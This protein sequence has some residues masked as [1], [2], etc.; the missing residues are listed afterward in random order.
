MTPDGVIGLDNNIPWRLPSDMKRFRGI[1]KEAGVVPMGRKTWDSLPAQFK[2]LKERYNV[3]LTR[4]CSLRTSDSVEFV[5]TLEDVYAAIAA[6]GGKGCIIGGEQIYRLFLPVVRVMH[7]TTVYASIAG[8][9]H[10]PQIDLKDWRIRDSTPER[11]PEGDEYSSSYE[12][13]ERV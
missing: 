4:D 10:F 13:L 5:T 1:T 11:H 12:M 2:P 7:I 9:A 8:D 3:I 6:H